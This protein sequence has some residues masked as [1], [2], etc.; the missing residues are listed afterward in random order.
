MYACFSFHFFS[1]PPVRCPALLLFLPKCCFPQDRRGK[2]GSQRVKNIFAFKRGNNF[3]LLHSVCICI[4][5]HHKHLH[6]KWF[7]SV[8]FMF[9][10]A[11]SIMVTCAATAPPP[12]L[13]SCVLSYVSFMGNPNNLTCPP[14]SP[15]VVSPVCVRMQ[16]VPLSVLHLSASD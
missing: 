16:Q 14:P 8:A 7:K 6:L 12:C 15:P 5:P 4:T 9:L 1:S 13:S 2:K 11:P 3:N 10:C